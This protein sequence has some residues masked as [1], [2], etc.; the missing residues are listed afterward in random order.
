MDRVLVLLGAV[1]G[2]LAVGAAA[3]AAHAPGWGGQSVRDAVQI[4]GWHALAA[5]GTGVWTRRGGWIA[6]VAGMAFLG[7]TVMFVGAVLAGSLLNVKT[8][9]LAPVGGITLMTGW[10]LLGLSALRAR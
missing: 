8:G 5:V 3:A 1:L 4:L 6:I 9:V 2:L 10:A 7:G